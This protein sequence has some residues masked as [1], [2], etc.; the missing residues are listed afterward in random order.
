MTMSLPSRLGRGLAVLGL[1][2]LLALAACNNDPQSGSLTI[3]YSFAPGVSCDQHAELVQSV[4][5]EVGGLG[6]EAIASESVACDNAGGE[7]VLPGVAAGN[8]DLFVLG[9]DDE[10]DAVLDNLGGD[11]GDDRIEIIGGDP[12]QADVLLGLAPA[13]LEVGLVVNNQ[14]FPAQCSSTEIMV[15]GVR[16]EAWDFGSSDLLKSHEFDLCDFDGFEVVPDMERDINGRRFDGVVIQPIDGTGNPVGSAVDL[17]FSGPVGA[18]KV[19]RVSVECE[20]DVCDVQLLGGDA[21]TTTSDPTGEDPTGGD[22]T[23]G[24]PTTGDPT[25]GGDT[26]AGSGSGG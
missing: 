25:S 5:V 3:N 13:L 26:T 22:P 18:G 7:I 24:D 10:D 2:S 14:G 8:Y 11:M 16:A 20:A 1:P 4:R 17:V 12:A 9:I 19:A 6:E 15:K 23:T 21:G